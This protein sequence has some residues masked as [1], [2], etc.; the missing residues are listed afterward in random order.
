MV[1]DGRRRPWTSS[2]SFP[3]STT[4]RSRILRRSRR[5]SSA[6]SR[7]GTGTVALSGDGGDELFAGY[8]R[9]FWTTR[10]WK[11][12]S[13]LPARLRRGAAGLIAAVSPRSWNR[14]Y[15]RVSRLL[16]SGLRVRLA[17]DKVHKLA[18][19]LDADRAETVYLRLVSQ[20][21]T[22]AR[23]VVGGEEPATPIT[24]PLRLA[25]LPGPRAAHD[26]SG[27]GERTCPTTFS[28]RWIGRRWG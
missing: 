25:R 13:P 11:N 27:C 18:A 4:S 22:P 12:I 7:A 20:W 15:D 17:G 24:G 16:P 8:N 6:R 21:Q 1:R 5:I 26:V 10:L 19:L 23:L 2:R 3:S 14:A 28:S 9:Y